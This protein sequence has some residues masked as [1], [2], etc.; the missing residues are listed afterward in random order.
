VSE[1]ACA[2]AAQPFGPE[3]ALLFAASAYIVATEVRGQKMA[4]LFRV[5]QF[6]CAA[7]C[8]AARSRRLERH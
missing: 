1:S 2:N 7:R 8:A 4:S 3:T 6:V 5:G